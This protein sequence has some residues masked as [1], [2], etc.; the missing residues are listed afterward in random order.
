MVDQVICASGVRLADIQ[1]VLVTIVPPLCAY[2]S[3]NQRTGTEG[4]TCVG[5][6]YTP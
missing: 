3:G 2:K 4:S 1:S 6:I 5:R